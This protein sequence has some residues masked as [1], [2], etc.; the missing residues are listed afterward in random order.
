MDSVPRTGKEER[1]Y[2]VHTSS[3]FHRSHLAIKI[4]KTH[5]AP[6]FSKTSPGFLGRD[7]K[8]NGPRPLPTKTHSY[9]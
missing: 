3:D 2:S 9:G 4:A 7:I 8:R 6:A 1:K 5:L